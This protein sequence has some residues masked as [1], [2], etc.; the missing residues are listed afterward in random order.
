[1]NKNHTA[2]KRPFEPDKGDKRKQPEEYSIFYFDRVE[3]KPV[4]IMFNDIK[5]MEG[6]FMIIEKSGDETNIPLH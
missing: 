6:N 3:K 1:M 2:H 5:R 4:G